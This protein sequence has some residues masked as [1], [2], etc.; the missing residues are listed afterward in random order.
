MSSEVLRLMSNDHYKVRTH[1]LRLDGNARTQREFGLDETK[2]LVL[3][4][5]SLAKFLQNTQV[6]KNLMQM[7]AL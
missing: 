5:S 1:Y 7:S 4:S 3:D 6:D 2:S